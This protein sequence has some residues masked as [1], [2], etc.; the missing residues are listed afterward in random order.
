MALTQAPGVSEIQRCLV[1]GRQRGED[2][3][4]RGWGSEGWV[5]GGAPW[6][7]ERGGTQ[8]PR[9]SG[10]CRAGGTPAEHSVQSGS[11]GQA[12]SLTCP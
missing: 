8:S 1:E 9:F 3:L 7:W 5:L 10:S 11:A 6:G 12:V 2:T 4:G